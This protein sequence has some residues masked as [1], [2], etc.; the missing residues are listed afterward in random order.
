MSKTK[1]VYW[2]PRLSQV[3]GENHWNLL[4]IEPQRLLNKFVEDTTDS[5][6]DRIKN[7]K[8]CPSFVNLG[9]NTFY[10]ENPMTN[11]FSVK[12]GQIDYKEGSMFIHYEGGDTIAYGL[13]YLFF[14]EDD[15]ELML[16]GPYFSETKYDR[17]AK[18]IPG[19]FNISK[20]F[21]PV[22][23]EMLCVS[24]DKHFRVEEHEHLAYFNFLTDDKVVL[25]RFDTNETLR[26]LSNTCATVSGWWKDVPLIKRYD[27]FLKT[28]T[29]KVVMAEIKKQLVE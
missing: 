11:E 9:K 8:R 29:N 16:T 15:L 2:S 26:K 20:W 24:K 10:I 3:Q 1:T 19:R 22:N 17:Y 28:K 13:S 25:K 21:R 6:D 14:C 7:L 12:D 4:F 5:K 23:I 27:R 18:L